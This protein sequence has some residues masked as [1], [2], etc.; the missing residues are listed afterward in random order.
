MCVSSEETQ[1]RKSE[2]PPTS[3]DIN[4]G[5]GNQKTRETSVLSLVTTRSSTPTTAKMSG[6]ISERISLVP[7][8]HK[9]CEYI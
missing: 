8:S 5:P 4:E 9:Q 1:Q 2:A 7:L 3:N 6:S